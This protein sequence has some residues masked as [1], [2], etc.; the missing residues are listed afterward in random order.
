MRAVGNETFHL[1]PVARGE[2]KILAQVIWR[3]EVIVV[4]VSSETPIPSVG[5]VI[6][7]CPLRLVRRTMGSETLHLGPSF[8]GEAQGKAEVNE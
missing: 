5:F 6:E 7:K 4:V 1:G 2:A 3:R 8:L